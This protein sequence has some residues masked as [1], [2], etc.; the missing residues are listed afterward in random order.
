MNDDTPQQESLG[1]IEFISEVTESTHAPQNIGDTK[2]PRHAI[3][4][5]EQTPLSI[6]GLILAFPFPVLIIVL[7][8][9]LD[10]IKDQNQAFGEGTMNAVLLYLLQFF[11]VPLLSL[12]SVIIGFVVTMNSKH[13]AKKIGYISFGITGLGFIILGLFLN[14]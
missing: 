2:G 14:S 13:I 11:V 1:P 4:A 6:T 5:K 8:M 7:W 3:E 10:V 9:T 12:I